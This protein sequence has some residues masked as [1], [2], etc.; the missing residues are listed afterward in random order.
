MTPTQDQWDRAA[1]VEDGAPDSQWLALACTL[2]TSHLK[3][4]REAGKTLV[5][6]WRRSKMGDVDINAGV[7]N[8]Y[9]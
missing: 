1:L 6:T 2:L 4:E 3:S 8:E 5:R 9:L 7:N